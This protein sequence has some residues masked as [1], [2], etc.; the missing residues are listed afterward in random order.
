MAPTAPAVTVTVIVYNDADRLPRAVESLRRQSLRDIEII[1]SDD[2][3]TD[4]TPEVA[5]ALAAQD[6]RIVY[7]RLPQNSGGCSAPRNA[8]IGLAKAPYLMFLDSDDEL[9]ERA[10]ELLLAE[11]E[12]DDE[13]D[14]AMGGVERV[15]TDTGAVSSWHPHLFAVKR[16]VR[17]IHASPDM[18]FEHLSTNKMYRREFI[19]RHDLRFPEGIHYEDQLFSAQAYCLARAFTVLPEPVYRWYISPFEA[20]DALSISNQRHRIENVR[21]RINVARLIDDFL[22]ASGNEAIKA[23]KDY[24]FLKHDLRMYTGDLPYRTH[25]WIK[26][27]NEEI[28]PY[29]ETLAPSA[30]ERLPRDQR[31][32]IQLVRSGRYEEAQLAARGLGRNIAPREV[33]EDGSG[34]V[35]WGPVVPADPDAARELEISDLDLRDRAFKSALLRHEI[36]R[37]SPGSGSRI[38]LDVRTYDPGNQLPMGPVVATVHVAPGRKRLSTSFRLDPVRPGL[39]E[40]SVT[41]DLGEAALPPHGFAGVR[42]PVLAITQHRQHNTRLLL[43]PLDFPALRKKIAYHRGMA[44]HTVTV[45]PEGHSAGRLQIRWERAGLLAKAEPHL[46]ALRKVAGPGLRRARGLLRGLAK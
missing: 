25:E 36:V 35:Y 24:K 3:S 31:V 29:L 28:S 42:H 6:D 26:Q 41:I 37:V 46:P 7:H 15:R 13:V 20:A 2:H 8:A 22:V 33:T 1:I 9:H 40:G 39:F 34:R 23:D 14:F 27:F 18:L 45:E 44:E 17:G 30:F 38:T 21:D 11:L 12:S 5:R 43:A 32:V 16:T 4:N 19:D 10:C